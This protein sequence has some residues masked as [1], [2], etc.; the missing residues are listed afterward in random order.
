MTL[1]ERRGPATRKLLR[2]L[3]RRRELAP[4]DRPAFDCSSWPNL[5]RREAVVFTDTADFTV[6][7]VRDG[8]LHFLMSFDRVAA[9]ARKVVRASGGR[10]IKAEG[11]SLL[12]TF[13]EWIELGRES[14]R[15][16]RTASSFG[17]LTHM[18][19]AGLLVESG[20]R[21]DNARGVDAR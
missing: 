7:T 14:D 9:A 20:S 6:R 16:I 21:G 18:P 11:D 4:E 3:R 12:L 19:R 17:K 1:F 10:V 2:Q 13:E 5:V 15:Q 8:I